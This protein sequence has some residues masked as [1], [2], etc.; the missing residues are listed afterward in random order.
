VH[1]HTNTFPVWW[2]HTKP[3]PDGAKFI[4]FLSATATRPFQPGDRGFAMKSLLE[5]L[6]HFFF[7]G[8]RK[9][10]EVGIT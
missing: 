9:E 5:E 10:V 1:F 7:M 3:F 2:T 4:E 8:S 6:L